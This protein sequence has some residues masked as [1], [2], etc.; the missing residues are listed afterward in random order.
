MKLTYP[1]PHD[2]VYLTLT[3]SIVK[4]GEQIEVD[5]GDEAVML[6][7]QGWKP[8]A[9]GKRFVTA[10]EEYVAATVADDKE[11]QA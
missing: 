5:D 1:G 9:A 11:G 3:Q 8:D 10:I 6:V 4:R 2:K 7:A